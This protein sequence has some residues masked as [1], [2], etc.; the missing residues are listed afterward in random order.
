MRGGKAAV[1]RMWGAVFDMPTLLQRGKFAD[2][3]EN[4]ERHQFWK[5]GHADFD[6]APV[7]GGWGFTGAICTDGASLCGGLGRTKLH[8][9]LLHPATVGERP[10]RVKAVEQANKYAILGDNTIVLG[11]DTGRRNAICTVVPTVSACYLRQ[12]VR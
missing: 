5:L 8:Q 12:D 4:V 7:Q 3:P 11:T 9:Q 1:K 6:G 2:L 10:R